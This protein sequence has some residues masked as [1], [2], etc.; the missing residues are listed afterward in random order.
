MVNLHDSCVCTTVVFAHNCM[1]SALKKACILHS[2]VAHMVTGCPAVSCELTLMKKV[3]DEKKIL[4]SA[5]AS[6]LP[7]FKSSMLTCNL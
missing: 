2:L 7:L 6:L 4:Q 5:E 1:S 3:K